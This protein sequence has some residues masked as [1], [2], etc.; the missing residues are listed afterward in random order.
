MELLE[1]LQW[2]ATKIIKGLE[3][4]CYEGRLRQLFCLEKGQLGGDLINVYEYL[5]EGECQADEA[6]LFSVVSSNRVRVNRQKLIHR[7]FHLDM[8]KNFTVWVTM[9]W[10][11]LP[12]G[13]GV[14]LDGDTPAPSGHSPVQCA[15][16]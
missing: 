6:R 1:Q 14:S 5:K 9:H 11:R 16:G 3:H 10:G 12:R 7:K 2:R 4:L 15:V 13:C 8:W